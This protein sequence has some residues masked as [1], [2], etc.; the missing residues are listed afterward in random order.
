MI[1]LVKIPDN[2][3]S[4]YRYEV[5]FKAYKWDPQVEDNNTVSQYV[6]VLDQ[7]T[8]NKLE[9]MAEKLSQETMAMEE[10]LLKNL[11]L[12][13]KLGYPHKIKKT[14]PNL[15]NYKRENNVRLM[16]FDFHPTTNGWNISEVN[17]DVPGGFAEASILP[18]LA[19]RYFPECQTRIHFGNTL[20]SAFQK[21]IVPS[22]TVAMVHA[23]SYTDDRQELQYISDYFN[24]HNLKTI[25]AA[26]DHLKWVDHKPVSIINNENIPID[27]I[28]RFFPLEWLCNLP[29]KTKWQGYYDCQVPSC[30]HPIAIFAQSKRL[31]LIWEQLRVNIPTWKQLLPPTIDPKMVKVTPGDWIYKPA[32]GRVGE[33]ISIKSAISEKELKKIEKAAHKEPKNWVA[34]QMFYSKPITASDN[35][36]FHLCIGVFTVDGKRAGFYGRISPYAR[37]DANAKDIPILVLKEKEN[38]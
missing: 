5:I 36:T 25:F 19:A 2:K 18:E 24:E 31:P 33:G 15:A 26:P 35:Q 13:K 21:K 30:N 23:T 8:A 37:I 28:F 6:A 38:G 22:G 27:G 34:Q 9:E 11:K 32:L 7:D 1:K 20:F 14:L 29:R 10:A 3:Y 16:R 17:S 12:T 4:E